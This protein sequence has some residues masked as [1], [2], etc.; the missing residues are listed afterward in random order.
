MGTVPAEAMSKGRSRRAATA[1]S[2]DV[3]AG[4]TEAH[5]IPEMSAKAGSLLHNRYPQITRF[6]EMISPAARREEEVAAPLIFPA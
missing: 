2:A 1:S 4:T 5:T 3:T 6:S